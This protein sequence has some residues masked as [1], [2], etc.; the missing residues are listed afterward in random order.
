MAESGDPKAWYK[1]DIWLI[2]IILLFAGV[3]LWNSRAI[4]FPDRFVETTEYSRF[5]VRFRHP[6]EADLWEVGLDSEN[7]FD[8][9]GAISPSDER[10]MVGYAS[11]GQE[12]AVTWAAVEQ[13]PAL[14][15]VLETHYRSVTL[16]AERRDRGITIIKGEL[17]AGEVNGHAMSL[18]FHEVELT[19]P[20][21]SEPLYG[22]GYVGGWYC[23][24]T[25]RF[26]IL[27]VYRWNPGQPPDQTEAQALTRFNAFLKTLRC[28]S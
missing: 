22:E 2:L 19:M 28:H 20:G 8:Y 16:N 4:L 9:T 5:E 17:L 14:E 12:T 6:V 13:A 11:E 23:Q 27:Y 18:Q 1:K 3:T 15:E 26:Y 24:N 7:I 25:G 10:G 21:S